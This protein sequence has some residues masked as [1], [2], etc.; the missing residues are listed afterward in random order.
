MPKANPVYFWEADCELEVRN[1]AFSLQAEEVKR[2]NIKTKVFHCDSIQDGQLVWNP[3]ARLKG[4][5]KAQTGVLRP[6][7][8]E[9]I[10]GGMKVYPADGGYD[11]IPIGKVSELAGVDTPPAPEGEYELPEGCP[12]PFKRFIIV[13]AEHGGTRS[14]TTYWLTLPK[15]ITVKL[16]IVSFARSISPETVKELLEKLGDKV[17]LGDKYSTGQY[18]LFKLKEFEAKSERLN[19]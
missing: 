2:G 19:I 14:T 11:S 6:S 1:I 18:G 16:K 5:L 8:G 7:Y 15:T 9:Q 3:S 10:S 13:K 4:W 17:G 12:F